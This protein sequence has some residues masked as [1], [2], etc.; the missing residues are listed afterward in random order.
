MAIIFG[1]QFRNSH[2]TAADRASKPDAVE[3]VNR[4]GSWQPT[5]GGRALRLARFVLVALLLCSSSAAAKP[6]QGLLLLHSYSQEYP[7]THR[8]NDGFIS[9]LTSD[10]TLTTEVSTEYLDTKRRRY[11]EADAVDMENYIRAKYAGYKPAAIYVTDDDALLFARDHLT[12]IFPGIPIFFSGVNNYDFGGSLDRALFTGVFELKEVAPNLKWLMEMDPLADDLIFV[13]D[14]SSTYLAIEKSATAEMSRYRKKSTFISES[15]LAK[16]VEKIRKASGEYVFLT[17]VGGMTDEGGHVIPLR[18]IIKALVSTGKTVVSMEDG[19]IMEGVLGGWVTSGAA[20]GAA[21]ARLMLAYLHGTP[22]MTLEPQR[23]SPN[24]MIFDEDALRK[25]N[26]EIPQAVRE[27]STILNPRATF[28]EAHREMILGLFAT[29]AA[30][31]LISVGIGIWALSRKN[32]ELKAARL[33]AEKSLESLQKIAESV[34][35]LLYQYRLRPDGSTSFPF[36]SKAISELYDVTP[37]EAIDDATKAGLKIHSEDRERVVASIKKSAEELS[38]WQQEYRVVFGGKTRMLSGNASPQ[39]EEDGSVLWHGFLADVTERKKDE[40]ELAKTSERLALAVKAA[41]VGIW[42]Y[43]IPANKL[44]WDAQMF[45]LYGVKAGD[46]DGGVEM[47]K[48]CLFDEDREMAWMD[49]QLAIDGKKEFDSEFRVVRSDG[50]VRN[51]RALA[52]VKR[53]RDG[54]PTHIVGTNW[55]I[56]L[57]KQIEANLLSSNRELETASAMAKAA[58]LAKSAFLAAMSHEIRTPLNGILGST[59]ILGRTELTEIQNELVQMVLT[60]GEHLLSTINAILDFSKIEAGQMETETVSF[61]LI[62]E[63]NKVLDVVGPSAMKKGIEVVFIPGKLPVGVKG[64]AMRITQ[65]LVNLVGNAVKFTEKGWVTITCEAGDGDNIKF[66]VKDTGIGIAPAKLSSLFDPF[67]QADSSITRKYGGTGLGLAIS[68]RL[69]HLMGGTLVVTSEL[70][71]GACFEFDLPLP[72]ASGWRP[73]VGTP[74]TVDLKGRTALVIDDMAINLR[75]VKHAFDEA[76]GSTLLANSLADGLG[77]LKKHLNVDL[78]LLDKLLPGTD[79]NDAVEALSGAAAGTPLILLTSDLLAAE[80]S[81]FA[82]VLQKPLKFHTLISVC[83]DVLDN[84]QRVLPTTK[85]EDAQKIGIKVLVAEDN[86][87]NQKV[88]ARFLN[89]L[90]VDDITMATDGQVAVEKWKNGNYDICLLT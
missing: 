32:C 30:M 3:A 9:A 83:R 19:Y 50:E 13:G 21:A 29:T 16:C 7:W 26:I 87:I 45:A 53:D 20:Q 42:E 58:S 55:D 51:I 18:D 59:E 72:V 80:R 85:Q 65:V 10:D 81:R 31:L 11:T 33:D 75:L 28:Y 12:N 25:N 38:A 70:G 5:P 90:G 62:D 64:D 1:Y 35:G 76:G 60:S 27:K 71:G 57:H 36:A 8:Q 24:A 14:G 82:A 4:C 41:A 78:I 88:V 74:G 77:L 40:S 6:V 67:T 39:K 79:S 37:S 73:N 69:V 2:R 48:R 23:V 54:R 61:S 34:P 86:L 52:V 46:F 15:N 49:F 56:T 43:D 63:I 89:T 44:T 22:M 68:S 66:Q 84:R 17:T 47:W